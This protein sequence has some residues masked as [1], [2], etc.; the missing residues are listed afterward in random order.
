MEHPGEKLPAQY[1]RSKAQIL[2]NPSSQLSAV[3]LDDTVNDIT[4][5]AFIIPQQSARV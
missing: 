3:T 2:D 1:G 5:K 4:E